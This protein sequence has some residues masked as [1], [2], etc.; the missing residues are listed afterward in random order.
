LCGDN[1]WNDLLVT[2][3][4]LEVEDK[5]APTMEWDT[6]AA[7]AIVRESKKMVYAYKSAHLLKYNKSELINPWFI[8]K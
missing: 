4:Y 8:A 6:A 7:D 5:Y 3:K 2:T 1:N